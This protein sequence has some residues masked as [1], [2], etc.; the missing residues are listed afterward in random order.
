MW[1]LKFLVDSKTLIVYRINAGGERQGEKTRW[2]I[3]ST[4]QVPRGLFW[5][6]SGIV[7]RCVNQEKKLGTGNFKKAVFRGLYESAK[8]C[9]CAVNS[10]VERADVIWYL[11]GNPFFAF[12]IH[13]GEVSKA[14]LQNL[15][16]SGAVLRWVVLV[17]DD[18][19][20]QYIPLK[21]KAQE[22][23]DEA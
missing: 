3:N 23:A 16:S 4:S 9:G 8:A 10:E 15:Q 2:K 22:E 18:G 17:K 14:R 12:Q 19:F 6:I 20:V 13:A 5:L 7:R 21:T 1:K 11:H